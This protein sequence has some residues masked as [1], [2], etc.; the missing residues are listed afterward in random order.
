MFDRKAYK[1][2]AKKQLQGRYGTP[3]LIML[4]TIGI[5]L[6]LNI[7]TF[8]QEG[9]MM[10]SGM[11]YMAIESGFS[12]L[13]GISFLMAFASFFIIGVIEIADARFYI[14][15]SRTTEKQTFSTYIKG[16]SLWL[17]GF[18]GMLWMMLW[19][20]LWA[21]LFYIPGIVKA[22]AYSQMFYIMA[23]HPDVGVRKSM[24][25]SMAITKGYKGDLFVMSLSFLGWAFLNCFTFG[26]LSFWLVP[27]MEM[28][29]TNAYHALKAQALK[30]GTVTAADFGPADPD[31]PGAG[32]TET[33]DSTDNGSAE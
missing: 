30:T 18:L 10:A 20:F 31:L 26:I 7:P 5:M 33:A 29:F 27:Y 25:L 1:Q 23:E 14:V 13:M 19:V 17:Q 12:S 3:I 15:M 8:I 4:F 6:I 28:S 11:E 9:R 21:L 32:T 16:F 22:Y 2:I 24:K